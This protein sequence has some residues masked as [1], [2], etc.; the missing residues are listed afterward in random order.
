MSHYACSL[1][2]G[3]GQSI[4]FSDQKKRWTGYSVIILASQLHKNRGTSCTAEYPTVYSLYCGPGLNLIPGGLYGLPLWVLISYH[5]QN[6]LVPYQKCRIQKNLIQFLKRLIDVIFCV[7]R[8]YGQWKAFRISRK[9]APFKPQLS[10]L[11]YQACS[12]V[13]I[14]ANRIEFFGWKAY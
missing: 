7:M 8:Y 11:A 10:I 2:A 3:S 4:A 6:T 13:W 1:Y 9:I 12:H 5:W 14:S